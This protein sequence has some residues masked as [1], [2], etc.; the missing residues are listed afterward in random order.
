MNTPKLP[1]RTRGASLAE[2][3]APKAANCAEC[4]NG[5]ECAWHW[6]QRHVEA[7]E[8]ECCVGLYSTCRNTNK[9]MS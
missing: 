6:S 1:Q 4:A 9:E 8:C 5:R 3:I 2:L 7:D